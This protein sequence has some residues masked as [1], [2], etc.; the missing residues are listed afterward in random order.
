MIASKQIAF[1]KAAGGNKLPDGVVQVEYLETDGESYL[2]MPN[3]FTSSSLGE[4]VKVEL[5][6]DI[7]VAQ[8]NTPI[9]V[10]G[11]SMSHRWCIVGDTIPSSLKLYCM[12]NFNKSFALSSPAKI[13]IEASINSVYMTIGETRDGGSHGSFMDDDFDIAI[14]SY[15]NGMNIAPAGQRIYG[16]RFIAGGHTLTDLI[17]VRVGDVGYM[18]DRVSGQLFGNQGTGEFVLGPDIIDY[19]AKDYVQDG[20]IWQWDVEG[21]QLITSTESIITNSVQRE[22]T[23]EMC[24]GT[25]TENVDYCR[26]MVG[27][28][29]MNQCYNTLF[30]SNGYPVQ[31]AYTGSS[32]YY[33]S[34]LTGPANDYFPRH[35]YEI[36]KPWHG[37]CAVDEMGVGR[38]SEPN[39]R[40]Y[41]DG[42]LLGEIYGV[43]SMFANEKLR[44]T[45]A[46]H[47]PSGKPS[48][49]NFLKSVLVY[50]RALT[51]EEVAHN[52]SIDKA[53]FGL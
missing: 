18:Y 35:G 19:T 20:L 32:Y 15:S 34:G 25:I 26:V 52:Y 23:I 40:Y 21:G 45:V 50:N 1:G 42:V 12:G 10:Q 3:R 16:Y 4:G 11:T 29:G 9:L 30:T 43:S 28:D 31:L 51:A 39:G 53:R 44:P 13:V 8:N 17:P 46:F 2:V 47:T 36:G 37:V 41:K 49:E 38:T 6:L 27:D 22:N 14:F 7:R 24:V 48:M 5:G 33:R